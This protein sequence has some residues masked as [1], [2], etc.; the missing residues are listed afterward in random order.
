MDTFTPC[1][2]PAAAEAGLQRAGELRLAS[3]RGRQ[4]RQQFAVEAGQLQAVALG[5]VGGA[6]GVTQVQVAAGQRRGQR[7]AE[8][9]QA[10]QRFGVEVAALAGTPAHALVV[11][12]QRHA[13]PV[14]GL[15]LHA[16]TA[17]VTAQ[18]RAAAAELM[19][20]EG[21]ARIQPRFAI[22][23]VVHDR[24]ADGD[25]QVAMQ[26]HAQ[27]GLQ[28]PVMV[29]R[30]TRDHPPALHE[31]LPAVVVPVHAGLVERR[32]LGAH[33][34]AVFDD[35]QGHPVA[36]GRKAGGIQFVDAALQIVGLQQ[37]LAVVGVHPRIAAQQ[38]RQR[39]ALPHR[40]LVDI[41]LGSAET[42]AFETVQRQHGKGKVATLCAGEI[43]A[44]HAPGLHVVTAGQIVAQV[45]IIEDQ[46]LVGAAAT[47]LLAVV[48]PVHADVRVA[49]H[50]EHAGALRGEALVLAPGAEVQALLVQQRVLR[51][52][53]GPVVALA[54]LTLRRQPPACQE[55][56]QRALA[57]VQDRRRA[58]GIVRRRQVA[59]ASTGLSTAAGQVAVARQL[60]RQGRQ[61]LFVCFFRQPQCRQHLR[62][63]LQAHA[64]RGDEHRPDAG[65]AP[66][67]P[68]VQLFGL[69]GHE[70]FET[71][72][73]RACGQRRAG[74][75]RT[76]RGCQSGM[77][78]GEK[79]HARI[80][81]VRPPAWATARDRRSAYGVPVPWA[82]TRLT[83]PS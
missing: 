11:H 44:V 33:Q 17:I 70:V 7:A 59:A 14:A 23:H 79:V 67:Q 6:A 55:Q 64:V 61:Q 45:Q 18:Q 8:R 20:A 37:A 56:V 49:Q 15:L 21:L 51:V 26:G 52:L 1:H 82:S 38:H 46:V 12:T 62:R 5:G 32:F 40:G 57:F 53:G 69:T 25:A 27:A 47:A 60:L 78:E 68:D 71:G 58:G 10:A 73:H 16:A 66:H 81:P 80:A 3:Q 2:T 22:G 19:G 43:A 83:M 34:H 29:A 74:Q 39:T 76:Q 9:V 65:R 42:D 24:R 35:A 13:A 28:C 41:R 36:A 75:R 50:A 48:G 31:P 54:D 30:A 77:R 4:P 72:R 63:L